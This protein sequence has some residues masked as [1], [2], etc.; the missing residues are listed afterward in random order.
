MAATRSLRI[1]ARA[2]GEGKVVQHT[3]ASGANV[4]FLKPCAKG[5]DLV[6]EQRHETFADRRIAAEESEQR[7]LRIEKSSLIPG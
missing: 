5:V 3:L 4:A 2:G 7:T 6:R 1:D